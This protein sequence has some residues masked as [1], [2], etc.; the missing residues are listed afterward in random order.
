MAEKDASMRMTLKLAYCSFFAE[1]S[2]SCSATAN[3]VN[4]ACFQVWKRFALNRIFLEV[5]IQ[6]EHIVGTITHY[7]GFL[8]FAHAL[9]E[10]VGFTL[11]RDHFHEIEWVSGVV[12]FAAT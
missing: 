1:F 10:E 3:L 6:R 7:A 9:F 2:G 12:N 11:Q 5:F 8:V 4:E